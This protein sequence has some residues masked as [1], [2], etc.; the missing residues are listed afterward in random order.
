[1]MN[2]PKQ[3]TIPPMPE[4]TNEKVN[5]PK[6]YNQPGKKECIDEMLELFGLQATLDF[7]W[8]NCY[9]YLYRAGQKEGNSAEQDIE[10]AKWYLEW[11]NKHEH[12]LTPS[13]MLDE[14]LADAYVKMTESNQQELKNYRVAY[15]DEEGNRCTVDIMS[16]DIDS[17]YRLADSRYGKGNVFSVH[18]TT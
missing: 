11:A 7:C 14:M 16:Y 6:H 9:K 4:G 15:Y 1:M 10:K 8:L 5:H 2:I 13:N 17:V 18:V 12:E 3:P